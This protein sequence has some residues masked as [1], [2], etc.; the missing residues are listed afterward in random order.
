MLFFS[1]IVIYSLTQIVT[2]FYVPIIRTRFLNL[3][4]SGLFMPFTSVILYEI[5]ISYAIGFNLS[6]TLWWS[7]NCVT[8][9]KFYISW[10]IT[11]I[12]LYWLWQH[13]RWNFWS[14][15]KGIHLFVRKTIYWVMNLTINSQFSVLLYMTV[16]TLTRII[17]III[18][19]FISLL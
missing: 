7:K 1:M 13:L 4:V 10:L 3:S 2:P 14:K 5:S 11:T 17:V 19:K 15:S 12:T 18:I 6:I 16:L 8:K 9:F